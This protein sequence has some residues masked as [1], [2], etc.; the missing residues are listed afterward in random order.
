MEGH[1]KPVSCYHTLHRLLTLHR[2]G[3]HA[4]N[5]T[6][7]PS[8]LVS[9]L[10]SRVHDRSYRLAYQARLYEKGPLAVYARAQFLKHA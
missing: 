8:L 3:W 10:Q 1:F 6:P 2:E 7:D 4:R 9:F 5:D